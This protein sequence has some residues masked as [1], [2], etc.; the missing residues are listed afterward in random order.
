MSSHI[1]R[2]AVIGSREYPR[3]D[4]VRHYV[5]TLHT[6]TIVV[7]GGARGV[8]K[9]AQDAAEVRGLT[10]DIY[11]ADWTRNGKA[12]G[13]IR[14]QQIADHAD[15]VTAFWDGSSRGT[16]DCVV[17]FHEQRKWITVYAATGASIPMADILVW[18]ERNGIWA[19]SGVRRASV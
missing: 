6:S 4:F 19:A 13:F 7:S 11:P 12:A 14:N 2:Q 18:A 10:V 1:V 17:R 16:I 5:S 3:L 8:D 15:R 9:Q